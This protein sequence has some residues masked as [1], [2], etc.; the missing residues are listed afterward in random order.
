MEEFDP[1]TLEILWA[2]LLT[3]VDEGAVSLRNAAF[4]LLVRE[5][6][7]FAVVLL[8]PEGNGIAR[9]SE[10]GF[11]FAVVV[12]S[13]AK[14]AIQKYGNSWQPGD[15]VIMNDPW[16]SSGHVND[17]T[18]LTPIFGEHGLA[19]FAGN[20]AHSSDIGGLRFGARGRDMFEEGLRLPALKLY[21]AGEPNKTLF[22][23]IRENVRLPEQVNGDI[24]SQIAANATAGR[25]LKELLKEFEI[26][27]LSS[28]STVIM[29]RSEAVMRAAISEIPDGVWS[30]EVKMDGIDETLTIR[31]TLEIK[32]SNINVDY[33][34]TSPQVDVPLNSVPNY[35][36][37]HTVYPI[38]A[39]LC[40]ASPKNDGALR[41][42]TVTAPPG[43]I[44]NPL[45]PAPVGTRHITGAFCSPAVLGA[46]AQVVPEK[47]I[48]E[49]GGTPNC[50]LVISGEREDGSPFGDIIFATGGM[51]ARPNAD[52]L[53]CVTFPVNTSASPV[54][55]LESTLP[56]RY[57]EKE[58][59]PDSAG[60][61]EYRGGFG[62]RHRF[63]V[64]SS[65]PIRFAPLVDRT[66]FPPMGLLGGKPG[67]LLKLWVDPPRNLPPK[68]YSILNPGDVVTIELP[69]GGG[70]GKPENRKPA[71]IE[72]D[73]KA[74][75]VTADQLTS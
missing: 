30:H 58:L 16:I 1:V 47:V 70:Y 56:I 4:S 22:E 64:V 57:E 14:H 63:R 46:L 31:A 68:E 11:T 13:A 69:G 59:I 41:P 55:V 75:L 8:D 49:S 23:M 40:P 24:E 37:A 34:G 44:L 36:Y 25:K 73:M 71:L 35:T 18:V 72:M 17:L 54:E 42:I 60:Q 45:R 32:G 19:G 29:S 51:G 10:G 33:T 50:S 39:A 28:L 7:D 26:K 53:S 3:I 74:G 52:G 65:K 66:K 12:P 62:A 61:G 5:S 27:N 9:N 43:C 20:S 21:S 48:A 67:T 38:M 6:N 2:R 15:V